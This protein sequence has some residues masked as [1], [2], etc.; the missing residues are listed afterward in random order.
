M[1]QKNSVQKKEKRKKKKIER[2][3][4]SAC[5]SVYETNSFS[6]KC[7]LFLVYTRT[8]IVWITELRKILFFFLLD[9]FFFLENYADTE[10]KVS[11]LHTFTKW[12][13]KRVLI[14]FTV[15]GTKKWGLS[16][17]ERLYWKS[18]HFSK[19]NFSFFIFHFSVFFF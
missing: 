18:F 5:E 14:L 3:R 10:W 12:A 15:H 9:F 11:V 1:T 16:F 7:L 13:K 19:K 4:E 8:Y 2:E 17:I 6:S